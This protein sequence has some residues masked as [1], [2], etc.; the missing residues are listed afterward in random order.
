MAADRSLPDIF[1]A[2]DRDNEVDDG[3]V[4]YKTLNRSGDVSA[5]RPDGLFPARCVSAPDIM[6]K[7]GE[8]LPY[9]ERSYPVQR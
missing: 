3:A 9:R 2:L 1:R 6:V 5:M 8:E 7:K 4:P